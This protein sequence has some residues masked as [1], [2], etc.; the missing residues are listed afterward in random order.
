MNRDDL[1]K[2]AIAVLRERVGW[3]TKIA[4]KLGVNARTVRRWVAADRVP[5]WAAGKL[6]KALRLSRKPGRNPES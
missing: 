6:E 4:K 5:E 3:Q 1:A 2:I